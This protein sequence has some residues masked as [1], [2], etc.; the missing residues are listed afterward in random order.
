MGELHDVSEDVPEGL[1]SRNL[2]PAFSRQELMAVLEWRVS[3]HEHFIDVQTDALTAAGGGP[4]LQEPGV[5]GSK[6]SCP[7]LDAALEFMREGDVFMAWR[8]DR[9][10]HSKPNVLHLMPSLALHLGA[11]ATGTSWQAFS[12][13]AS[14]GKH[15]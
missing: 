11:N 15:Q 9:A 13:A 5:S 10:G 1:C 8:L 3:T 7:R 6:A 4:N 14:D 12:C 2:I